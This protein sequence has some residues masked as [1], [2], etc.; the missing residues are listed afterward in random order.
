M[1][2]VYNPVST[3]WATAH[4]KVRLVQGLRVA[5]RRTYRAL[6]EGF[7]DMVRDS[8]V[9][10]MRAAERAET[11]LFRL[12]SA[13]PE[14]F[15]SCGGAAHSVSFGIVRRVLR[16]VVWSVEW[17]VLVRQAL[18]LRAGSPPARRE[19]RGVVSESPVCV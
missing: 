18:A 11:C 17:R 16:C 2:R 12:Q 15:D 3:T 10:Q 4:R 14:R 5:H 1:R 8:R 6:S 7:V 9:E 13:E 19:V